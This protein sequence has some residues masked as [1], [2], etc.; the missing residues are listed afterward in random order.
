MEEAKL[1]K[2]NAINGKEIVLAEPTLSSSNTLDLLLVGIN[3]TII[4]YQRKENRVIMD[5]NEKKLLLKISD[6]D[7]KFLAGFFDENFSKANDYY[8]RLKSKK[9]KYLY[10]ED[11]SLVTTEEIL[12]NGYSTYYINLTN[13]ILKSLGTSLEDLIDKVSTSKDKLALVDN[14]FGVHYEFNLESIG[15]GG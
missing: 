4:K 6:E 5:L 9:V 10:Y 15:I 3:D 1:I 11:E 12:E 13:H 7:L 8:K 14:D 2:V